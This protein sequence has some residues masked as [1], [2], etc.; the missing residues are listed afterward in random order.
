MPAGAPKKESL[1]ASQEEFCKEYIFDFNAT[2]AYQKAY[3]E[4]SYESA[5]SSSCDL[6]RKPKIQDYIKTLQ[7]DLEKQANISRLMVLQ[8]HKKLAFSSMS[9]LHDTWITRKEFEE[10]GE[11]ERDCISEIQTRVVKKNIGTKQEPEIVDVEEIKVKLYDK[12][13]ALDS[14]SKMLGYNEA[15]K[16]AVSGSMI[17]YN[18]DVTKEEAKRISDMLEDEC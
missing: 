17:N 4:S 11:D 10:L 13:K 8:E 15:E 6:L 18:T 5:M 12:Q 1:N 7:E 2:R 9:R 3:P 14:I 16:H